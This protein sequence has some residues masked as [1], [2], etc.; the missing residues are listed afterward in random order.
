MQASIVLD[1]CRGKTYMPWTPQPVFNQEGWHLLRK[2]FR[3]LNYGDRFR[4]R[5]VPAGAINLIVRLTLKLA[6]CG[7]AYVYLFKRRLLARTQTAGLV[8]LLR[9]G[10]VHN[11]GQ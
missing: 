8:L 10:D 9:C 5:E 3:I 2:L 11:T 7:G 4:S 1:E 6:T